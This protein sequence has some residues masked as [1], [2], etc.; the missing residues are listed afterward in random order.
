[1]ILYKLYQKIQ[2]K[3]YRNPVERLREQ[4]A[5]IGNNVHIYDGGGASIDYDF[6][7]LLKIGNNV[8]LSNTTLLLHDA[9]PKKQLNMI[10]IGKITIGNDVFVG[11]NS[12][13]LPNVHIG[14]RVIIGAGSVVTKDVPDGV[15]AAG[16]PARAIRTYD[17]Y[18]KK[19]S[20]WME[21]KPC[22]KESQIKDEKE[23]VRQNIRDW[24]V[25][26]KEDY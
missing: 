22:F 24:A 12:V 20:E 16:N 13:I 10:K 9:S 18:M 7:F 11:A 1:M 8:T 19:C 21:N 25:L 15:V 6:G 14:N 17:D 4:G 23:K 2:A 3:L 5:D 26:E